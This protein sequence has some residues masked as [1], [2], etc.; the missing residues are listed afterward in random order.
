[1]SGYGIFARYYDALTAN[2]DYT[3]RARYFDELL[4]RY[5]A[6]RFEHPELEMPQPKLVLDLACG[7]GSLSFALQDLGYEVIGADASSEML[8]LAVSKSYELDTAERPVFLNQEMDKLD[9]YGTV[10][11]TVCALDS[12]NHVESEDMLL[13][14]FKKVSLFTNPGGLFIFDANTLHKHRDVLAC[15]TFIYDLPQVF[16]AWQNMYDESGHRVDITLDFFEK[17]DSAYKRSTES[18]SEYFYSEKRL[19]ELLEKSG[20]EHLATLVDNSLDS[21]AEA[22]RLVYVAKKPNYSKST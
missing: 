14:S 16:C 3:A 6:P 1:M 17:L 9:L 20:F 13:A 8:S 7:T 5:W 11:A 21:D 10:D 22:Q 15:N 2:I 19:V 4:R 18:F 12:V